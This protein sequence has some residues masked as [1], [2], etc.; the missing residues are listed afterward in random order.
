M[1][2]CVIILNVFYVCYVFRGFGNGDVSNDGRGHKTRMG[3]GKRDG[4]GGRDDRERDKR[5]RG[6]VD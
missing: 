6:V 4:G 2:V 3:K 5:V 1:L